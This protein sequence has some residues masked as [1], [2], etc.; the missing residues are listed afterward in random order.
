MQAIMQ[1]SEA[2]ERFVRKFLN[3]MFPE[4]TI[5]SWVVDAL[6]A[7]DIHIQDMVRQKNG[8][9]ETLAVNLNNSGEKRHRPNAEDD[10]DLR[11]HPRNE[12]NDR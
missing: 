4:G 5:P 2:F 8:H 6:T 3:D 1:G 11:K 12:A 7:A 9:D 10:H